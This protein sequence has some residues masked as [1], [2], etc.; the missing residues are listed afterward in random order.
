[1]TD[2]ELSLI[3]RRHPRRSF[4]RGSTLFSLGALSAIG[5][6]SSASAWGKAKSASQGEDAA[7][8]NAALALEFQAI[9]AYQLGAESGLLQKPVLDI[10][11]KFQGHHK[12]H[13][14]ALTGAIEQISGIAVLAKRI[15][16]YAFP[17]DQLKTQADVL[18]FAAGL[19]KGAA[20]TYLKS[21]PI[22]HDKHLVQAAGSILGDES[23]HWAVLLNALGEDPVPAAFLS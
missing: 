7:I 18:R 5:L 4:F 20:S 12:N 11:L 19:E 14:Q 21:L 22:F 3:D 6:G 8:L 9:A 16:E 17:I 23:M 1:M 10:A 15:E 13:A 2:T